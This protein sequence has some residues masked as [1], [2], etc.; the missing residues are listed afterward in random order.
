MKIMMV[1]IKKGRMARQ[2]VILISLQNASDRP[3]IL[4]L[5]W[6]CFFVT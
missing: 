2:N 6:H 5:N 4:K 3:A 1:I